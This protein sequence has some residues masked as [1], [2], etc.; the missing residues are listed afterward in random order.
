[1]SASEYFAVSESDTLTLEECRRALRLAASDIQK[2][3]L[4]AELWKT[5]TPTA[6]NINVLPEPLRRYVHDL[7]T[8][9][10]PAGNLQELHCL[11]EQLKQ[12]RA[13][14]FR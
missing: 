10:D 6:D 14:D 12:I 2:A 1:M 3:E 9:A 11:R 7:E 4:A 13:Q 5:W 8:N